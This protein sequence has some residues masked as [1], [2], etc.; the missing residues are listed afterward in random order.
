[1]TS[2]D[3]A[4]PLVIIMN[5]AGLNKEKGVLLSLQDKI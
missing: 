3:G 4:H 2:T 1:M 5:T